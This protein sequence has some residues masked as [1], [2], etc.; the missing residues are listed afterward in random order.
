[1]RLHII[2][3]RAKGADGYEQMNEAE[4]SGGPDAPTWDTNM[5]KGDKTPP[6]RARV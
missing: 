1:M 5:P 3:E 4:G 6:Q 2:D